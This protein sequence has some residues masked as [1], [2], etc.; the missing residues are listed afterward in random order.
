MANSFGRVAL[1]NCSIRGKQ[2]YAGG[3]RNDGATAQ[4]T[5]RNCRISGNTGVT[6]GGGILNGGALEVENTTIDGN[7][8]PK[9]GGIFHEGASLKLTN[10]TISGNTATDNGGG[11]YAARE[12]VLR[13]VTFA[14]NGAG[15]AG[16]DLFV[17]EAQVAVGRLALCGGGRP[18][19]LRDQRRT[20]RRLGR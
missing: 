20:P 3:V 19:E 5:I 6:R 9:G 7:S 2:G 8:A 18:A 17:D 4:M 11:L 14:G 16:G 15:G 13:Y 1:A 12:T 10:V